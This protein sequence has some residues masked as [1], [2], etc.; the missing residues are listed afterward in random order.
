MTGDALSRN[1]RLNKINAVLNEFR[2]PE[3]TLANLGDAERGRCEI[4][5]MLDFAALDE[6]RVRIRFLLRDPRRGDHEIDLAFGEPLTCVVPHLYASQSD[7]ADRRWKIG[8]VK[9]WL[10][11]ATDWTYELPRASTHAEDTSADPTSETAAH[12]VL[13][14]V[15]GKDF[16]DAL[17]TEDVVPLGKF[18]IPGEFYPA[19]AVM[20]RARVV[21]SYRRRSGDGELV[22]LATDQILTLSRSGKFAND[23][24]TSAALFRASLKPEP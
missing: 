18:H 10:V 1:E 22:L 21:Q 17:A 6:R 5:D 19:S 13:A 11:G 7:A 16:L 24:L 4:L 2:L 9:R 23:I 15:F 14:H 8:L 3:W 12:R 20:L